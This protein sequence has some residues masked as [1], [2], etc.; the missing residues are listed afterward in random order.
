[1]S[2]KELFAALLSTDN[3]VRT[4]A[5]VRKNFL[6]KFVKELEIA[7]HVYLTRKLVKFQKVNFFR[8]T[9]RFVLNLQS[10]QRIFTRKVVKFRKFNF[11]PSNCNFLF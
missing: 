8:Q 5:E 9:A 6:K 11:F 1:M 3:N 10:D 7:Y 2:A 4:E